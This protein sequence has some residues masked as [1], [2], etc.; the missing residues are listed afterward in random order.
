MYIVLS[1]LLLLLES[2]V[3]LIYAYGKTDDIGYHGKR[4]GTKEVNLLK[5]MPRSRPPDINYLDC[6]GEC[7]C[8]CRTYSTYYH[9]KV[10]KVPNLNRNNYIIRIEPVIEHLD[11]VHHML[12]YG[13]PLSL[14]QT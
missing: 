12:V 9:C 11:L 6:W 1:P 4:R 3:K 7:Y 10:T 13:C 8:P 5:F 14:K 2:L